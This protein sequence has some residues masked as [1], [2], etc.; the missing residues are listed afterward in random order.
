M[1]STVLSNFMLKGK[2]LSVTGPILRRRYH[3]LASHLVGGA[4]ARLGE[5]ADQSIPSWKNR[6]ES[7]LRLRRGAYV[8]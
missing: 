4:S 7:K 1:L 8:V 6:H 2:E 5:L 3:A